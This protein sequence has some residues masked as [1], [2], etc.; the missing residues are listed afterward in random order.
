LVL[1]GQRIRRFG[2]TQRTHGF[3]LVTKDSDLG[4][5]AILRGAPPKVLWLRIGNCSTPAVEQLLRARARDVEEFAANPDRIV[6]EL[7][8]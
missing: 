2:S 5:L 7:F 1:S 8:D 4:E 6:F 3:L